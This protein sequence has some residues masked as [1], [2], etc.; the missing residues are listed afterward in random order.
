MCEVCA[1]FGR[2][3]HWTARASG[4]STALEAFDIHRHRAE[5]REAL[6]VLNVVLEAEGVRVD[7]WDG[8]SYQV[9]LPS[10]AFVKAEDLADVWPALRRLGVEPPDL[11][12][13]DRDAAGRSGAGE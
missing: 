13:A 8:E 2:G 6:R 12:D 1:V 10:G 3:R 9:S 5:R 7:D 4:D 11:L